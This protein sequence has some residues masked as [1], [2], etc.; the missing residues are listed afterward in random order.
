MSSRDVIRALAPL[1]PPEECALEMVAVARRK[2]RQGWIKLFVSSVCG[3]IMQS[4][5]A[6]VSI[7]VQGNSISGQHVGG[8][9]DWLPKVPEAGAYSI[10]LILITMFGLDLFNSNILF[11]TVGCATRKLSPWALLKSWVVSWFG[12]LGGALFVSYIFAYST[13][14]ARSEGMVNASYVSVNNKLTNPTWAQLFARAVA[15]N[16]LV[17]MGIYL[18]FMCR[19]F[20]AKYIAILIPVFAF[21]YIG[22][23]H[24]VADMFLISLG[25][26]NG[27]PHS[28]GLF[29]HKSLVGVSVGNIVGGSVF[30]LVVPW[31]LH[32]FTVSALHIKDSIAGVNADGVQ[33]GTEVGEEEPKEEPSSSSAGESFNPPQAPASARIAPHAQSPV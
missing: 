31:Y 11:F 21:V 22:F 29:I 14:L 24:V 9:N 16:A 13:G 1:I 28:V 6:F 8:A 17:C 32:Y 23:D 27:S 7:T 25:L 33:I 4:I 20:V 10:G 30:A 5:G 12:N 18:S 2:H 26:F 15:C 19:T 3:G